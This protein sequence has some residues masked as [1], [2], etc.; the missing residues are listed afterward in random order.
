MAAVGQYFLKKRGAAMGLA[1]GGSSLGGVIFPIALS[2]MLSNPKLGFGW[3][4]RICG[5]IMLAVMIPS[6]LAIRARLP[7]RKTG[8]LIPKAFKEVPYIALI[9][10]LF[11]TMMGV[12]I[13]IF[14]LPSYAV[15]KGLRRLPFQTQTNH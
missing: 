6:T 5:F 9:A 11:L 8:F 14:Y 15:T 1:V 13:P 10:A 4:V 2:K 12:F 7:P 3:S